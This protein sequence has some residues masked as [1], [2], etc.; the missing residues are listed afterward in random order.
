MRSYLKNDFALDYFKNNKFRWFSDR[1]PDYTNLT[2]L[3]FIGYALNLCE[4]WDIFLDIGAGEGRYSR[5]LAKR[6]KRG[7]AVESTGNEQFDCLSK[8]R[9]NIKCINKYI[10]QVN[11]KEKID[12]VFLADVFEHIPS[13]DVDS[14]VK[15]IDSIQQIGGVVYV[16]TPNA[17]HCGPA[18]FSGLYHTKLPD[19]HYKHYLKEEVDA[20]FLKY[21]YSRIL[22][23]YEDTYFRLLIKHGVMLISIFDKKMSKNETFKLLTWPLVY[24]MQIMCKTTEYLV[25]FVEVLN[26]NNIFSTQSMVLVYKKIKSK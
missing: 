8:D 14:F 15:K 19:G 16:L 20:Y 17:I 4:K 22:L 13:E 1:L 9:P 7:Y 23:A 3:K 11:F 21:G 6:F 12:F 5:A 10:Q 18:R 2:T 24:V 25:D 26:R